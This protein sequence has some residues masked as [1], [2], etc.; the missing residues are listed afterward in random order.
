MLEDSVDNLN[1]DGEQNT[2][3]NDLDL[4]EQLENLK[5]C[6]EGPGET[7]QSSNKILLKSNPIFDEKNASTKVQH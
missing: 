5:I 2:S 3:C 7:S 6:D 1:I 4:L